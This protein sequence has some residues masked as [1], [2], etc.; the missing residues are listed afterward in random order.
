MIPWLVAGGAMLGLWLLS[1]HTGFFAPQGARVYLLGD[2]LSVGTH[3]PGGQLAQLLRHAG[4]S[5][6]VRAVGGWT[7][8]Q[9]VRSQRADILSDVLSF[10]PTVILV[11][12][13]T[14][15]EANIAAGGNA[16]ALLNAHAQL[17][18]LFPPSVQV[19]LIGPPQVDPSVIRG[20]PLVEVLPWLYNQ[21]R[22]LYGAYLIDTRPYAKPRPGNVH[23]DAKHA[24]IF[25]EQ[26]YERLTGQKPVPA[27]PPLHTRAAVLRWLSSVK[28]SA[29]R[30]G[31]S[32]ALLLALMEHES[33]G[34]PNAI[35]YL[36]GVPYGRGLMQLLPETAE[37][38]GVNYHDP[39][40]NIDGGAHLMAELLHHYGGD[41]RPALAAYFAGKGGVHDHGWEH[42]SHYVNAILSRKPAYEGL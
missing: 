41:E 35:G 33:G 22:A 12:L 37:Q 18:G 24:A 26:V 31:V 4:A 11:C 39:I 34:D 21:F 27:P 16:Q 5:V 9:F 2:S 28:Q 36:D 25:A 15:E 20:R 29:A 14:N 1:R 6:L 10:A 38:Y 30:W 23:L 19:I 8:L 13:G 7:A 42:Y 17:R 40:A 3:S 32:V